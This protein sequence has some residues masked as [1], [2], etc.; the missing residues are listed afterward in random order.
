MG[1]AG[2]SQKTGKK[3]DKDTTMSYEVTHL[4]EMV[5]EGDM[6]SLLNN[7]E[8]EINKIIE[9][10]DHHIRNFEVKRYIQS[11]R[12][13]TELKRAKKYLGMISTRIPSR[14]AR[15]VKDIRM[16]I[17]LAEDSA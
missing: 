7:L 14:L 6:Y 4:D 10:G 9:A 11:I 15:T 17:S 1:T 2:Q 12:K 8:S 5:D 16:L 3:Q 13:S